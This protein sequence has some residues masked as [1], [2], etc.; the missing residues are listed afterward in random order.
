MNFYDFH[1]G[2]YA[3]RTAH[4]EPMEDL[5]YR[6]MLDLYY[7]REDALPHELERIAKLIRLKGQE[8]AIESVLGEFFTLDRDRG[9]VHGKCEEVI[10]TAQ[11][12]RAKAQASANKRWHSEGNA[13]AMQSHSEGNAPIPTTQSQ[14]HSQKKPPQPPK[15]EPQGFAEFYAAYP[16]KEARVKAAKAFAKVTAPLADLLSALEWQ[17]RLE[18][19]RKEGGKF[20]PLPA[21]WLNDERWKDERPTSREGDAPDWHQS[22]S[23]VE[24]RA[25][26]LGLKPWNE[27]EEHWPV[28]RQRVMAADKAATSGGGLTLDQLMALAPPRKTA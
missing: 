27:A 22:R 7:V 5:A 26:E 17:R 8:D 2:D 18:G 15:G 19:W 1:I 9:W 28:Y 24:G 3:S 23:G 14:S 12:K 10:A 13:D 6:R 25:K 4:L 21:S 16:R 11:E 20:V